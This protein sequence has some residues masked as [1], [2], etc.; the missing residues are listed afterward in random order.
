MLIRFSRQKNRSIRLIQRLI[1]PCRSILLLAALGTTAACGQP[2]WL[3][4]AHKIEVQQGN[5]ISEEQKSLVRRGQSRQEVLDAIGQPV[6]GNV[7]R[8]ERWD[9]AYSRG[10]A[11]S[12]IETRKLTLIFGNDKVVEIKDNYDETTGEIVTKR[13]WWQRWFGGKTG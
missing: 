8:G 7:F 5:L 3:P 12:A 6:L 11:G 2:W 13:R 10:P 9:Y 4:P 1:K